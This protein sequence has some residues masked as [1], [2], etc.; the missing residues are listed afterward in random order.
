MPKNLLV[1]ESPGKIKKISQILGV[2]WLIK[3]SIGHFRI[4]ANDGEDNL[5]FDFVGDRISMRFQPKDLKSQKTIEELKEA[6]GKVAK[7]FIATDPDREGEVIA[8]HLWEILKGV[9]RNIVRVTF[10]EIS[11]NA[12]NK[13]IAFPR[14]LDSHLVD[15]GLARS[16]LDKLVGF[17]GSPLVWNLGA[18]SIG[19]VQSAVL[20]LVCDRE[21]EINNFQPEDYFSVFVKYAEGFRSF[22]S[23]GGRASN[24]TPNES[25]NESE[26]EK[27]QT[28]STRIYQRFQAENLVEIAKSCP[29]KIVRVEQKTTSKNPPPPLITSSLQQESGS[30]LGLSPDRTMKVAQSLYEKGLITYMR[31]DS[32][33]L[34]EEFCDAAKAWLENKDPQNVLEKPRKHQKAKNSQEA[35]EAIRPSDLSYSSVKLKQEIGDEEFKL[36]LLIWKRA[37]ASQC[38][39]ALIDRTIVLS[40]SGSVFWQAKGQMVKFIGYAKYWNNLSADSQLPTLLPEQTLELSKAEIESKRTSPPSRYGEPQLVA[41]ME[42]KGIGR[43]STYSS[44]IKTIKARSYVKISQ[45]KLIPTEL[46]MTVDSF[47]GKNFA[48][49]I[50]AQFTAGMEASL[51]EIAQGEKKWQP[52]LTSWNQ[53][54]FSPALALAKLTLPESNRKPKGTTILSEYKCPVCDQ[55]LEQ[56]NYLKENEQKSLLRC[57]DPKSRN[58]S[59]HKQ[60]VFFLTR[61]DNW[62]S[63]KYGELGEPTSQQNLKK[64][65]QSTKKSSPIKLKTQQK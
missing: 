52:Y 32:V 10:A 39:P 13:A 20:H 54:Y 18:K 24:V 27:P 64:K 4:L 46:G 43:P 51:D 30:K 55:N 2:N 65:C 31:T 41:L 15:A 63:K 59:N 38:R 8:W 60:V 33:V 53:T 7:V 36:Y 19:R 16:L 12:V 47:L 58:K 49:L 21:K 50:D 42:K 35:H 34:S 57:C 29:H 14:Q 1:V 25:E 26:L 3:A 45:N 22:Y 23:Y 6:A 48:D 44:S 61:N 37:I 56:Y 17:K 11:A 9:N 5:G 62:W 28:E 40:Q